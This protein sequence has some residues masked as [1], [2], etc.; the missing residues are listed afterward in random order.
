MKSI[1]Q[2]FL[3]LSI[4]MALGLTAQ[5]PQ[6]VNYQAVARNAAGT[7]IANQAV[8]V[9]FT[10]HD[11]T[12]GGTTVY[13]ETHTGLTTNQFGLFTTAIGTGTPVGTSTFAGINWGTNAK[14]LEVELDPAGG[15]NYMNM[16]TTQLNAVPYALYAATSGS[17]AGATGATGPA[18]ANGTNGATGA[19]GLTGPTG[20]NG[21]NGSNGS[22]GAVG[23]TGP[24]GPTGTNG[25]AGATGPS[26]SGG[27]P[28]G[29]TG[30]TGATGSGG[31]STGAT[32][33][34][35]PT[36]A[37]GPTG[38]NGSNGTNG[39]NGAAG[40]TGPTGP[41][42][43]AGTA[44]A[45]GHTGVT[46]PT[47]ANG[48]SGS[49]GTTGP[50]GVA[51]ATGPTGAGTTGAT[52]PT[53]SG[54]ASGTI[55]Y[56]SK[57]T[58]AT[59]LGNSQL[60]DNGTNVGIGTVSARAKIYLKTALTTA[61]NIGTYDS[62]TG[63]SSATASYFGTFS[64]LGG[65]GLYNAAVDGNSYGTNTHENDGGNFVASGSTLNVGVDG[66]GYGANA[67]G[68]NYG[69]YFTGQNSGYLNV[70]ARGDAQNASSAPNIGIVGVTDSSTNNNIGIEGE[71]DGS[72]PGS[73]NDGVAGFAE[74]SNDV[75]SSNT[76]LQGVAGSSR[77][78]NFGVYAESDSSTG[79][80]G[81]S[82]GFPSNIAIYA[83]SLCNTC[84]NNLTLGNSLAG[85]FFG[86][87][88][89]EGNIQA[90][91]SVT[92]SVKNF[93]IDHPLDP[94]NKY[95]VHS[96]VESSDMMNMYNG[97]ITTDANGEAIVS[98]PS[99]FQAANKDYR[100]QLTVIGTFAQAIVAKEVEN[101]QFVVKTNQPNVKV[102]WQVTGIRND[103]YAQAHPMVVEEDKGVQRGKYLAPELFGKGNESKIGGID[104]SRF[105]TN[106]MSYTAMK[107]SVP[108]HSASGTK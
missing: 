38:S 94:A 10:I 92:G 48:T 46:G 101:N 73:A 58:S 80:A 76:G 99:Y 54:S 16:G 106:R 32:G 28:T 12:L 82:Q 26:G 69:G 59:A 43:A 35:G 71:A 79:T 40:S 45:T 13:Q 41:A 86:D 98:L 7:V 55:N 15:T 51:G 65:Q 102:S 36:G 93:K 83:Q 4:L 23:S 22:N 3:A 70:G 33:A 49:A 97:N 53:G 2:L 52:G 47:G 95:L 56:I 20:A 21:T 100:Y 24:T 62:V 89:I 67:T 90:S 74:Y 104:T 25:I 72:L 1:R 66:T 108:N 11:A 44:G 61:V 39:S 75:N 64:S 57:F 87:V 105:K 27:G 78:Y 30:P 31:G 19:N 81:S 96:V 85:A 42:G 5:V 6:Q 91:G 60:F 107:K 17:G 9:R 50:T 29:P 14:Y 34:V 18:G 103:A 77:G 88:F 68:S 84:T 63:P 37:A 8:S